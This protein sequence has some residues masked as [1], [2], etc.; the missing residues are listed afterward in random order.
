MKHFRKLEQ[1][2]VLEINGILASL[3]DTYDIVRLVDVEECR[4]LEVEED[5]SIR[6]R[7]ECFHI[8]NRRTRCENCSS[9]RACRTHDCQDK[10]EYLGPDREK[11]HSVPIY[12]ELV[13]GDL[14]LCVIECVRYA[15]T[16]EA[17]AKAAGSSDA[18][19]STHD[20]LTRLYT[21]EKLFRQIRQRL[22]DRPDQRYYLVMT[23][24]RNF[25]LI[26]KLFGIEGGNRLLVGVAD[27]LR[28]NCG[29]EEI[30]GRFRD[31]RFL[32]LIRQDRFDEAAMV[33]SLKKTERLLDSPIFHID[34]KLGVYKIRNVNLPL[35]A[36]IEYA[37]LAVNTIRDDGEVR[38]AYY[39]PSMMEQKRKDRNA[40]TDF[41]Q[42]LRKGEFCIYLQPQVRADG[43]VRGAEALVRWILPDGT[44]RLPGE[45][46]GV[47]QQSELLSHLDVYVWELAVRQLRRWQGTPF[48]RLPIS[49]NVDPTDFYFVDVPGVL[50]DLCRQ[51]DVDPAL[52][53]VEITETV[54]VE[55]IEKQSRMVDRLQ[56]AG[57]LVEIDD[58]GKGFSSLSLLKDIR[59]DVLKIDMGFLRGAQNLDRSRI[60]LASVIEMAGNLNMDVIS[61]GVETREQVEKLTAIGCRSFQGFYFSRPI[62]VEDFERVAAQNL[63]G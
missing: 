3:R 45:F 55:D 47:L 52:L 43:R 57:F 50:A 1:Y 32:L 29:R 48:A 15:G 25:A 31:D 30:Y 56:S 28:A 59:A 39:S 34:I 2:S 36:M 38:L 19:I 4:I 6:Y 51:Y 27:M 17:G 60:I 42:A 21:P 8:W 9:Y 49:V 61:E 23:N 62:P 63:A 35:S 26:N 33:E 53:R 24:I 5:G 44:V 12:L 54:L 40:I 13:G 46:L 58:F 22:M 37:D 16:D 10:T 7:Q 11:I 41:E 18:Y 14:A 20:V